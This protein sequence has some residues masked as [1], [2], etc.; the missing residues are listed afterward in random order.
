[1]IN[2]LEGVFEGANGQD[3]YQTI[4]PYFLEQYNNSYDL[5]IVVTASNEPNSGFAA[6]AINIYSHADNGRPILGRIVNT[7]KTAFQPS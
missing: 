5:L 2:R 4:C 6:W 7:I 3:C 1:M